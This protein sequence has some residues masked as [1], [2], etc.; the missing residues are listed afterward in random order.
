[1]ELFVEQLRTQV[2]NS[3]LPNDAFMIVE[4]ADIS[5]PINERA[6]YNIILRDSKGG[7]ITAALFP[8]NTYAK[9]EEAKTAWQQKVQG[10]IALR[11]KKVK[12]TKIGKKTSFQSVP[13]LQLSTSFQ[14]EL[15]ATTQT[16]LQIPPVTGPPLA[17]STPVPA[18]VSSKPTIEQV[19]AAFLQVWQTSK[20]LDTE[21]Q[22]LY[23]LIHAFR[24]GTK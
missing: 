13:Q 15:L 17:P 11:G 23:N 7:E 8:V 10:F 6:P 1:M 2:D 19:M 22:E 12:L 24:D 4:I 9:T 18:P 14:Y 5:D 21:M 20:Q 16:T 3:K